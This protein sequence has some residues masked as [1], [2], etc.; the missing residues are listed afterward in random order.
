MV[1]SIYTRAIGADDAIAVAG[2]ELQVSAREEL[3]AAEGEGHVVDCQH[4]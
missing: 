4:G 1:L 3:L 2:Q